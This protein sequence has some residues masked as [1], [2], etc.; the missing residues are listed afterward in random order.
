MDKQSWDAYKQS[1]RGRRCIELFRTDPEDTLER[2]LAVWK[3]LWRLPSAP[4]T[5]EDEDWFCSDYLRYEYNLEEKGFFKALDTH[6]A[7]VT[8]LE[9]L[10][11]HYYK[12][13][14]D[15]LALLT[16]DNRPVFDEENVDIAKDDYLT[17]AE[18][19]FTLSLVFYYRMEYYKPLGFFRR[20]DIVQKHC[21]RLG[22]A[23]PTPPPADDA[24]AHL[25]YYDDLCTA[26]CLFQEKNGLS[27]AEFCA[28]LFDYAA[29]LPDPADGG[30]EKPRLVLWT[31]SDPKSEG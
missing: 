23:L 12:V 27:D 6:E 9:D 20:F 26:W 16:D 29:T 24:R 17:K 3:F 7:F 28:C 2:A 4:I 18:E 31:M 14:D 21:A 1:E 15:G 30:R 13:G 19:L 22:I 11:V 8:A 5:K 10:V 25:G